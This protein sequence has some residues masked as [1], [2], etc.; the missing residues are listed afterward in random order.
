MAKGRDCCFRYHCPH[1]AQV[2]VVLDRLPAP[3][4][5]RSE[6]DG[7]WEVHLDLPEQR[8]LY[9]FLVDGRYRVPDYS[10]GDP[11]YDGAGNLV[12]VLEGN[13]PS[14]GRSSGSARRRD[15]RKGA[16]TRNPGELHQQA[17]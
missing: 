14:A 12:S 13:C 4:C 17:G 16:S 11:V 6:G 7:W 10:A 5:M 2:E 1:A 3:I 15:S 9:H 8:C